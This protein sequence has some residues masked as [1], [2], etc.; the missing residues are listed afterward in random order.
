MLDRLVALG[1]I[2]EANGCDAAAA[3]DGSCSDGRGC[4][5]ACASCSLCAKSLFS[6]SQARIWRL[7]AKGRQAL[8]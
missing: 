6:A 8:A 4:C 7:S 5:S 2:E 1:Y 3:P